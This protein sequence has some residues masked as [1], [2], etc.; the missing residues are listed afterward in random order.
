MSRDGLLPPRFEKIHPKYQTPSFSTIITGLVVGVPLLFTDK[1]FVLDFT[2]IATLFAFVL[3]CG[4]VLLIPR[5][6]KEPGKFNMPYINGKFIFPLIIIVTIFV[7]AFLAVNQS[8]HNYFSEL[9]NGDFKDHSNDNLKDLLYFN[10]P[11]LKLSTIIFWIIL[12]ILAVISFLKN[13]SLIPLLGL[14][15]CLYLLTGMTGK[16]WAWFSSWL[17]LGLIVYFSYGYRKSKLA[18]G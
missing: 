6:E 2:S 1:V 15:S 9:L 17:A 18:K 10:N 7:L 14:A 8:G 13:L 5:K 4:G 11:S 3:V 16:N 12:L